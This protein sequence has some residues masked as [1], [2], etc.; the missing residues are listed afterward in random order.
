[1]TFDE[2]WRANLAQK[3]RRT[4]SAKRKDLPATRSLIVKD[5]NELQL[6]DVFP[7]V[8]FLRRRRPDGYFYPF[9]QRK[10]RAP[11]S[12]LRQLFLLCDGPPDSGHCV[13]RLLKPISSLEC[14]AP[15]FPIF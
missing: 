12:R 4:D 7:R 11:R 10:S 3:Q 1:M 15:L 9:R 6:T 8:A 5:P 2:L 13:G 14:S